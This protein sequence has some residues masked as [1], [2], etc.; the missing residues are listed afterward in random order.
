M[1]S[2]RRVVRAAVLAAALALF[3]LAGLSRAEIAQKG[4]L[5]VTFAGEI[6]PKRLPRKGVAPIAV[7]V[8][9]QVSTIDHSEPPQLRRIEIAINKAG[10]LDFRGLPL[11]HLEEIQPSTTQNALAACGASKVG[12]GAFSANVSIPGQAPF[13]SRGK[14]FA[15]IG[16][17]EGHPMIF[18]HVYGT[19]P[20][21]TSFTLP[22]R[23]GHAK[24]A[25][26]T[27]LIA[28]LPNVTGK[29]GFI[30]GIELKLYRTFSYRG[31]THSFLSAGC[32]APKGFKGAVFPLARASF[33]FAGGRTLGSVLTRNCWARR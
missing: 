14:M 6:R 12:E 1:M 13:P 9:G 5:R 8:G 3:A 33:V 16:T 23:I 30:T 25:F 11:C 29:A 17:D 20:V 4:P 22:L 32:P 15:F 19:D 2:P 21:P 24:G 7:S 10:R 26:S 31:R 18:A 27:T 28:S